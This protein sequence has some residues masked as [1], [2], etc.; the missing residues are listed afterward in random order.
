MLRCSLIAPSAQHNNGCLRGARRENR[1]MEPN[2]ATCAADRDD[3]SE[4][5]PPEEPDFEE[6]L[7]VPSRNLAL[8]TILFASAPL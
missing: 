8:L 7:E 2:S 1:R 5:P 6:K 3:E 4:E